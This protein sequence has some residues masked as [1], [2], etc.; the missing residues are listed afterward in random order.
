[1]HC[2]GSIQ[3]RG[4][5][6]LREPGAP[7]SVQALTG[8]FHRQATG[9]YDLNVLNL[10]FVPPEPKE[11][12]VNTLE[13]RL[14]LYVAPGIYDQLRPIIE[15]L[16][17]LEQEVVCEIIASSDGEIFEGI[18][19]DGCFSHEQ[20]EAFKSYR[21]QSIA[22][23]KLIDAFK[24]NPKFNQI[25]QIKGAFLEGAVQYTPKSDVTC[26]LPLIF[27]REKTDQLFSNDRAKWNEALDCLLNPEKLRN[28]LEN[29]NHL[30]AIRQQ[31]DSGKLNLNEVLI[32]T[33][34]GD[35][36][37]DDELFFK[38]ILNVRQWAIKTLQKD[39]GTPSVVVVHGSNRVELDERKQSL[40]NICT[41]FGLTA[42]D[43]NL[44]TEDEFCQK[45]DLATA[46][47][48]TLVHI[49]KVTF[50]LATKIL[51]SNVM[52]PKFDIISQS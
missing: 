51:K 4:L 40:A 11:K 10:W 7:Y 13:K 22:S 35:D 43:V 42:G 27:G 9:E 30:A 41:E 29:P 36:D 17:Q 21:D 8:L 1:M 5:G 44:Y 32:I 2:E 19:K 15:H 52:E 24:A 28:L 20:I 38:A 23:I 49:A 50:D 14:N 39:I 45:D 31:I 37:P 33:D 48:S 3:D 16:K 26:V 47:Y 18:T 34:P 46:Q 25:Q 6:L 12:A